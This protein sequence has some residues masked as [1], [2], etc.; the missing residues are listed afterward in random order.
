MLQL[1]GDGKYADVLEQALYNG[2]LSGVSQDGIRFFYENPLASV[3]LHHRQRW[4]SCSCCPT[5]IMRLL[6]ALGG[7]IYSQ[8]ADGLSID[9]YAQGEMD[10]TLAD[11]TRVSLAQ[12]TDYPWDGR[13]G[14]TV[15]PAREV[16]WTLR[17]RVPAWCRAFTL[18]VNGVRQ[19]LP[20]VAGYLALNRTWCAGDAV[21][22]DLDMPIERLEAHPAIAEDRG[23]VA[24]QRGALVYC[25][26]DVDHADASVQQIALPDSATLTARFAADLLGGVVVIEG[27]ATM[28]DG[29]GWGKTL[30]RPA[31]DAQSVGTPVAIRAIPYFA[32]DNRTP[33]GM[34]VWISRA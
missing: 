4:F 32:W 29:S 27:E 7:Y 34:V 6:P 33:G 1:T 22:L 21:V 15:T 28:I 11:G 14:V 26:E 25:L 31:Q 23:H 2:V 9:L 5:N 17:L 20:V 13:V 18:S 19:Q 16:S 30:Y 10:T 8:T 3:G 12:Q 24:L